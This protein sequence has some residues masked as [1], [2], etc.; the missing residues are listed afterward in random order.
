[1]EVIYTSHTTNTSSYSP[2]YC[3]RLY[4][5]FDLSEISSPRVLNQD[6]SER[7]EEVQSTLKISTHFEETSDVSTTYMGKLCHTG[8]NFEFEN[9][10][11]VS[12]NCTSQGVLMDKTPMRVLFDT[13][14]SK[15]YMSKS[16]YIANTSLH[17]LPK[18]S[19]SSKG[20]I[21]GD[22]QLVSVMFIISRH[23]LHS[24]LHV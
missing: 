7:F 17:T 12:C 16:F 13:G 9:Q 20:I 14:A 5:C 23:T 6:C 22:A 21:V 11:F 2:L 8:R 4:V 15:S 18:F 10:T 1:M 19:T 3:E 24:G